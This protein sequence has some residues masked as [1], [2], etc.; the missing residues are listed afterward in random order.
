[1]GTR[2]SRRSG[3]SSGSSSL[4]AGTSTVRGGFEAL[5]QRLGHQRPDAR[6][7]DPRGRRRRGRPRA[8][9]PPRASARP[10]AGAGQRFQEA[11]QG[12]RRTPG[13]ASTDCVG[14]ASRAPRPHTG[15]PARPTPGRRPSRR[16]AA[17][18][19]PSRARPQALAVSRSTP[20]DDRGGLRVAESW[21]PRA[22]TS[23]STSSPSSR[24]SSWPESGEE[25]V[26]R[27]HG[28][29]PVSS[30]R[31]PRRSPSDPSTS[32]A[33]TIARRCCGRYPAARRAASS[34][35][36]ARW[37]ATTW[38]RGRIGPAEAAGAC[39]AL[40]LF[41]SRRLVLVEGSRRGRPTPIKAAWSRTPPTRR[42]TPSW[43]S[44]WRAGAAQG[45]PAAQDRPRRRPPVLRGSHGRQAHRPRQRAGATPRRPAR[46]RRGAAARRPRRRAARAARRGAAQA[47]D[48]SDGEE[49]DE[50]VVD[51]LVFDFDARD[52]PPWTLLDHF[53]RRDRG[54]PSR[55][56]SG[57]TASAALRPAWCR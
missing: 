1:M 46:A 41:S 29:G 23:S 55:S 13:V 56:W 48:W 24:R 31:W 19:A 25:S 51:A 22:S 16:R 3:S 57:S 47:G 5:L 40:G 10:C 26:Q 54:R 49:V 30:Q 32:S 35:T 36:T 53:S 43:L 8:A 28:H 44:S 6:C 42:P 52:R 37:S 7:R 21:T 50:R 33:A 45:P 27:V 38:R 17:G 4:P 11:A 15:W 12:Q 2:E 39:N 18:R 9:T 14:H 20:R 34:A